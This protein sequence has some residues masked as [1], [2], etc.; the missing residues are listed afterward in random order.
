MKKRAFY[1]VRR[2]F[3]RFN[4]WLFLVCT[5]LAVLIFFITMYVEDP[6]SLR[7]SLAAIPALSVSAV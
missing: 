7:E 3:R 4:P 6:Y 5:V 2:F 1:L